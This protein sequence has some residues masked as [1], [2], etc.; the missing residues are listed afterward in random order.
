MEQFRDFMGMQLHGVSMWNYGYA[1][2]A[3]FGGFMLKWI[4]SLVLRR[5]SKVADKTKIKFDD[6]VIRALDKPL[7]WGFVLAGVFAAVVLLP[8]PEEPV[9]ISRFLVAVCTGAA[10]LIGVWFCLKLID[11]F[12]EYLQAKAAKT[13]SKLDDQIVPIARRSMKVFLVLL[14]A[15]LFL[16][17]LGY[18]VGSLIAGVGISGAAMAFAAKDTLAN[19]FGVL[20]IFLD[21]PFQVGDWIEVAGIEGTVEEIGLRITRVRTFANSLI[22]V[23]NHK[24]TE[25]VI[26]NWSQMRK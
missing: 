26:N 24:F 18:S 7:G 10:T 19:F 6:I 8:F 14:G 2:L 17:N 20:V 4:T 9:D 15:V 5:L 23:P 1:F 13:E 16:Q 11:G 3:V 21:K 12:G 25:G 22:T